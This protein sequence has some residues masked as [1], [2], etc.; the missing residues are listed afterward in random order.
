MD[1]INVANAKL[2]KG[3]DKIEKFGSTSL[4]SK[5]NIVPHKDMKTL[6]FGFPHNAYI[7]ARGDEP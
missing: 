3:G 6:D 1:V 5:I 7:S 4:Y 2:M